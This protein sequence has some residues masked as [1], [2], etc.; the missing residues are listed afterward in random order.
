[1]LNTTMYGMKAMVVGCAVADDVVYSGD[2]YA[3]ILSTSSQCLRE[4]KDDLMTCY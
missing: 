3:S 4:I 2:R 1:M